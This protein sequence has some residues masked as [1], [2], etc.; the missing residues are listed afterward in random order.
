MIRC[1]IDTNVPVT[2]NG[3]SDPGDTRMPS[4]E[5]RIAAVTFLQ[6]V[7]NRGRV[8]LDLAGSIQDEYRRHLNPR[9]Q[10]GVD[11]R[12][13]QV[14]LHSTPHLVE[15]LD[16]PQRADGEYQHVP[17]S[18]IDA[19]FDPSDRKF[20]AMARREGVPIIN[21]TDSDWVNDAATLAAEAI[22]VRHLCGNDVTK[23]FET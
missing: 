19:G 14:V 5:C 12:F 2:A 17:Q 4:V 16:L 23:W 13:Y 7:S 9:G 3:R 6:N 20:V 10:P 21:A 11:D 22:E 1:V 15:R 18:L 8:L